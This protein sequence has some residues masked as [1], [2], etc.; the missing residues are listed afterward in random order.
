MQTYLGQHR[1]K[2]RES[3]TQLTDT[4]CHP[5]TSYAN[6]TGEGWSSPSEPWGFFHPCWFFSKGLKAQCS[7][8]VP[9]VY[10][11][12]NHG[13]SQ[14]CTRTGNTS[15]YE[16][17][18]PWSGN[19]YQVTRGKARFSVDKKPFWPAN[20]TQILR[21]SGFQDICDLKM[22]GE[23]PLKIWQIVYESLCLKWYRKY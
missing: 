6:C 10:N 23:S 14:F 20:N 21:I 3:G 16:A 12:L 8:V 5:I 2:K 4:H 17:N 18:S 9:T 11:A 7:K 19:P 22:L 1:W 13:R 15:M